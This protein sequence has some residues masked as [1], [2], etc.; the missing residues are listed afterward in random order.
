VPNALASPLPDRRLGRS[1]EP[2]GML[3]VVPGDGHQLIQDRASLCPGAG[4]VPRPT[5]SINSLRLAMLTRLITF[6]WSG[7]P[8]RPDASY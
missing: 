3:A 6:L 2:D 8:I 5:A 4:P 1:R 7:R